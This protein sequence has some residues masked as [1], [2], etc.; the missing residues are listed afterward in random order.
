M[1][2][3]IISSLTGCQSIDDSL[4]N[5][6]FANSSIMN[7]IHKEL[8]DQTT[9]VDELY[10]T[11]II[12]KEVWEAMNA[13]V[14]SITRSVAT[15][16]NGGVV[17][18]S[19]YASPVT[20]TADPSATATPTPIPV[21]I[22]SK[23]RHPFIVTV[24][25]SMTYF[26][27]PVEEL[28]GYVTVNGLSDK[29]NAA[30]NIKKFGGS[31]ALYQGYPTKLIIQKEKP[32]DSNNNNT[33]YDG[34]AYFT[35]DKA[36]PL[37][38][39][40]DP[41]S[42]TSPVKGLVSRINSFGNLQVCYLNPDT[43]TTSADLFRLKTK[44]DE[45]KA[46]T[47]KDT[48]LLN[49]FFYPAEKIN[50]LSSELTVKQAYNVVEI[51]V[52]EN[53]VLVAKYK[54]CKLNKDAIRKAYGGD[55]ESGDF[56]SGVVIGDYFFVT[57]YPV[58]IFR[59]FESLES[60]PT[61]YIPVFTHPY[62]L[63]GDKYGD[64][65][66]SVFEGTAP[67]TENFKSGDKGTAES[68]CAYVDL[69]TGVMYYKG[70]KIG[71]AHDFMGTGTADLESSV[72]VRSSNFVYIDDK[73]PNCI[74]TVTQTNKFKPTETLNLT[75]SKSITLP[76]TSGATMP[77]VFLM[78][79]LELIY[80][81]NTA[82]T[83]AFTAY[84]RKIRLDENYILGNTALTAS[85]PSVAYI[86]GEGVF[87]KDWAMRTSSDGC[88]ALNMSE[89][90]DIDGIYENGADMKPKSKK[91]DGEV[92]DVSAS[93][94][95]I[96]AGSV[97]EQVGTV[98]SGDIAAE[99]SDNLPQIS[100][101]NI[102]CVMMFGAAGLDAA[103]STAEPKTPLYGITVYGGLYDKALFSNWI[104]AS[105]NANLLKWA[106]TLTALGYKNYTIS[107][108]VLTEKLKGNYAFELNNHEG[109]LNLDLDTI[110]EINKENIEERRGSWVIF[111]RTSLLILGFALISYVSV[112]LAAWALDVNLDLGLNLL[113]KVSFR[114]FVAV[115][116]LDEMP[117]PDP[118]S[119]TTYVDFRRLI[120]RCLAFAS[121]G[122]ILITIDPVNLIVKLLSWL[123]FLFKVLG[124]KLFGFK[125][126]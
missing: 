2:I 26:M 7:S 81:P 98:R 79:Y 58:A 87:Q 100:A 49:E 99:R 17:E 36:I 116:S 109:I 90:L 104:N 83:D 33:N 89:F 12:T 50:I 40:G 24:L 97:F 19:P 123:N 120:V 62:F 80:S 102:E 107:D 91:T 6:A 25:Q 126:M 27:N 74:T 71:N 47:I 84:G 118:D 4:I 23:D 119:V 72:L 54:M 30:E 46:G 18:T 77:V 121:M 125:L 59:G 65:K 5:N 10:R 75:S 103:D 61:K 11:G 1:L 88:I 106:K 53:N 37:Y 3:L 113:E 42:D 67:Y 14:S 29:D 111:L 95:F 78:E 66:G 114:H 44:I 21:E 57:R 15:L 60:D 39:F 101:G 105:G 86:V 41:D 76:V 85:S 13:Q 63:S 32:F 20:E 96:P 8:Q 68:K 43:V 108:A 48:E 124:E 94:R 110:V 73:N 64:L 69:Y 117:D 9:F 35:E 28:A 38:P 93:I 115:R 31:I 56:S 16:T 52:K 112:L 122:V 34:L 22:I 45:A 70:E 92:K 82:G 51:P 55:K